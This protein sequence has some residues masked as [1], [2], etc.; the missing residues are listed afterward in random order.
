MR[1][2]TRINIGAMH[3]V[4]WVVEAWGCSA[5]SLR[6]QKALQS[7][8]DSLISELRLRPVGNTVW[9]QFPGNGGIT[10]LSLLS[11]SH[12][13]CHT[14]PE[15]E[16]LCLNLF[17]CVPRAVWD[18][19]AELRNRFGAKEVSVRKLIRSYESSRERAASD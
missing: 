6:D 4:E 13:S 9:H 5:Q 16:S 1:Q 18:F 11:E 8:F 12:L 14:F 19:E 15:H 3:G 10:G 2:A 7:L 17:C